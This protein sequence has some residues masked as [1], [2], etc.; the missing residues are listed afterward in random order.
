MGDAALQLVNA[1]TGDNFGARPSPKGGKIAY[2]SNRTGDPELWL[3]DTGGG[4]ESRLTKAPSSELYPDWSPDGEQLAFVS[5]A[6][7]PFQVYVLDI[8]S[9]T[10]RLLVD[11]PLSI[12]GSNIINASIFARWSPD[13]EDLRIAF[14][15]S[16]D[17]GHALWTVRPDGSELEHALDDVYGFDWYLDS[18]R[19]LITRQRD[20]G[21]TDLLAVHLESGDT[22]LLATLPHTE[23]AVAPDGTAVSFC[24]GPGHL[25]MDLYVLELEVPADAEGLPAARGDAVRRTDG[26]GR[27]HAHNGGWF[28]DS[29][30]LVF[31][32]DEDYGD[33]YE[34]IET[35]AP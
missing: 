22:R 17:L 14:I 30:T 9:G 2:H 10:H 15:V 34:L 19:G 7:G 26:E 31:T 27:W 21:R 8:E 28:S 35:R 1:H 29:R 16:S 4:P 12:H 23:L 13:P 25:R 24:S 33:V 18:R 5:D 20:D 6:E 11:K 3:L 32:R